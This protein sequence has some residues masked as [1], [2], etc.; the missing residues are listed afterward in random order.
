M[1]R[2]LR[3]RRAAYVT[4]GAEDPTSSRIGALVA[5]QN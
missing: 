4:I 2:V 3:S 1:K 5:R